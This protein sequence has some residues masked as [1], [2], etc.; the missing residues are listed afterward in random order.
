MEKAHMNYIGKITGTFGIKG[1]L[2]VYTES[3]FVSYR[4]RKDAILFLVHQKDIV[5]VKVESMRIHKHAVLIRLYQ[6]A[7][8]NSVQNYVGYDVY[9]NASDEPELDENE[10]ALDDLIHLEVYSTD[11]LYQGIVNDF[12]AVPQGYIMEIKNQEKK[13]LIPFVDEYIVEILED[14]IIIQVLEVC[15]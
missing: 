2:K 9:A 15:R 6:Y 3:D 8:I 10:Y 4:F 14:K 12:I 11:H 1:E 7:D 13:M 5:Q